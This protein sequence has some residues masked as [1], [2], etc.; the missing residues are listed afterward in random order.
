MLQAQ[1]FEIAAEKKSSVDCTV[2]WADEGSG[3]S[4]FGNG[5]RKQ[6]LGV[7]VGYG[8]EKVELFHLSPEPKTENNNRT[9]CAL[10]IQ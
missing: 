6:L 7:P 5:I 8:I 1:G 4:G 3:R 2:T 10:Q 9:D